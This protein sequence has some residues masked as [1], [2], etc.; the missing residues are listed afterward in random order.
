MLFLL[1]HFT[2]LEEEESK[3][4]AEEGKEEAEGEEKQV[5]P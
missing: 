4:E 3:A 1:T 5:K 2:Y